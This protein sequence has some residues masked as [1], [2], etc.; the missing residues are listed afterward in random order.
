VAGAY[1]VWVVAFRR[2]DRCLLLIP[3][4]R[5]KPAKQGIREPVFFG[6]LWDQM[7]RLGTSEWPAHWV[8]TRRKGDRSSEA[9]EV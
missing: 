1:S 4:I 6:W 3:I 7:A 2:L 9:V 8:G 5:R